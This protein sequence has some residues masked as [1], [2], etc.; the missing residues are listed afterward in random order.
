MSQ[1]AHKLIA[2]YMGKYPDGHYIEAITLAG[3]LHAIS[4]ASRCDGYWHEKS[5]IGFRHEIWDIERFEAEP[6]EAS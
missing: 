2:E 4:L 3:R 1:R 6:V 5:S